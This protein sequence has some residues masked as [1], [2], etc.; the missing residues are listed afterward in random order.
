[1]T[2][3]PIPQ[4]AFPIANVI[5]PQS[6]PK[7]VP[8]TLDFSA[9]ASYDIDGQG[10]IDAHGIEYIQ[11]VFIDNADNAVPF[12]IT[13]GG[14]GHRVVVGPNSQGFYP[15]LVQTPPRFTAQSTQAAGRKVVCTFYNVPIMTSAWKSV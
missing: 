15:L 11:G 14:T 4:F 10:I 2:G 3:I 13:C 6:G 12:T 1:M 9:T 5:V 8:A 7:C